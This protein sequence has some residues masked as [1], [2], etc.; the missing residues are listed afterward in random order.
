VSSKHCSGQPLPCALTTRF[1]SILTGSYR[2]FKNSYFT[3]V[4][5]PPCSVCGSP[6]LALGVTPPTQDE[7][8]RGGKRVEL[9]R[10]SSQEVCGAYERFPRYGDVWTLLQTR[11]G[12]CGE[13]VDCFTML[14]KA[15]GSRVRWVW[16]AEDLVWTEVY[17]D[18]QRRWIHIDVCEG[19]WDE[20][21]LYTEGEPHPIPPMCP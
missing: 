20:P 18:H 16:N 4:N 15:M 10:C 19:V 13:W 1:S 11:R 3:W 17:S 7:S 8:A 21:R 5:N 12:R 14:C 6:T 2:W 9:Y